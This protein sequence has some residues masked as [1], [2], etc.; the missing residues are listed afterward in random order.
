MAEK[1]SDEFPGEASMRL[2]VATFPFLDFLLG[3]FVMVNLIAQSM[4]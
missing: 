4:M 1:K 2:A 3:C